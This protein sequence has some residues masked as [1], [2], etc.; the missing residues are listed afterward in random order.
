MISINSLIPV[1]SLKRRLKIFSNWLFKHR[2]EVKFNEVIRILFKA[3]GRKKA[4]NRITSIEISNGF[5]KVSIKGLKDHLYWP[6]ECDIEGLYLIIGETFDR[7]DWHFYE[8]PFTRVGASDVVLDIGA[9]EGLFSLNIV[10]RCGKIILVEPNHK[11]FGALNRT[12]LEYTASGKVMLHDVA[13]GSKNG[14]V[15]IT[16]AGVLSEIS[17]SGAV[18]KM[19]T[20]DELLTSESKVDYIKMDVEGY[21]SEV[22]SGAKNIIVKHKP[23]MAITCYHPANDFASMIKFVKELVPEYKVYL[24]GITSRVKPKP[25]MMHFFTGKDERK[26]GD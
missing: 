19:I 11:L 24:K 7:H 21:E 25:V 2:Y 8:H 13:L 17:E 4:L 26:K 9:A 5:K 1:R 12:F 6:A 3:S 20:A 22:L 14:D 23:K 10:N 18:C 15:K 16:D